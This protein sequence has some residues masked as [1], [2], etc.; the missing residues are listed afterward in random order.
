MAELGQSSNPKDLVPG[1]PAAVRST[2]ASFNKFGAALV[3]AGDGLKR[4]DTSD[5]KGDAADAFH[6]AFD[7][8]PTRWIQCGDAFQ[9]AAEA[10]TAYVE[11]LEW[12]QSQAA[13]AI[14]EWDAAQTA[15]QQAHAAHDH[16]VQQEQQRAAQA[17]ASGVPTAP[18][19]IPFVDPGE[20]QRAAAQDLLHRARLQLIEAGDVANSAVGQARD[21]AP[22]KPSLLDKIGS[23]FKNFGEGVWD[24]VKE[25]GEFAWT[26]DPAR[27][28]VEPKAALQGW[29][30][31]GTGVAS[32]V[33]H[34]VEFGKALID[35][36]EFQ[37][38]PARAVGHVFPDAALALV[39]GAGLVK[40]TG[41]LGKL[42]DLGTA[43]RDSARLGEA[44]TGRYAGKT[45]AELA[46]TG[47]EG[48]GVPGK[49]RKMVVRQVETPEELDKMFNDLSRG[50]HAVDKPTLNGKAI[51][52]PD[53]TTM[54]YRYAAGST[55]KP[56]IQIT[57]ADGHDVKIHLPK[58]N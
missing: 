12:A 26:I 3:R 31:L 20:P 4:L 13:E 7:G 24:S 45:A 5:W 56:A 2:I 50:G 10:L 38:N 55:Q 37:T 43:L 30:A 22:P 15:T 36:N 53:G 21:Q 9:S 42:A 57:S 6:E 1:E 51:E 34:P 52:F 54:T 46:Q 29:E 19:P 39:G 32:A 40:K 28:M 17:S 49:G 25:F 35:Y 8:E 44:A 14:H 27:F 11:V 16:A 41:T 18:Q 58:D 47:G 33:M 23:A 48:I